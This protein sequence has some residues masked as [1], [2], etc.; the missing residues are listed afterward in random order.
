M[1]KKRIPLFVKETNLATPVKA[2]SFPFSFKQIFD[3]CL[4][5]LRL[6]S[7]GTHHY[8]FPRLYLA[9][10]LLTYI[11]FYF[12]I[13]R[14]ETMPL[15]IF[16]RL[17]S[18]NFIWS[19]LEYFVTLIGNNPIQAPKG[20]GSKKGPSPLSKICCVDAR[21]MKL[22][23]KVQWYVKVCEMLNLCTRHFKFC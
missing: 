14:D 5:N 6:L 19:I 15:Q 13:S 12:L 20:W 21:D 11:H 16:E 3:I 23:E 4:S 18:T 1:L 10:I 22:G 17:S 8:Y 7:I 2:L 9:L